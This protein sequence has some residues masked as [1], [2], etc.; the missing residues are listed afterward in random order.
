MQ[1][2]G[3]VAVVTGAAS[4]VGRALAIELA[5][6]RARLVLVDRDAAGLVETGELVAGAGTTASQHIVDVADEDAMHA[7]ARDAEVAS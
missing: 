7:L 6:Q 4:G 3:K 2:A 1:L 5:T